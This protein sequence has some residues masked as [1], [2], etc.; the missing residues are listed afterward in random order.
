MQKLF[1]ET[2]LLCFAELTLTHYLSKFAQSH[3]I[4][5]NFD[6]KLLGSNNPWPNLSY[7]LT[8]LWITNGALS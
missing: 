6:N 2:T 1:D 5:A 3:M 8:K 4:S 7:L